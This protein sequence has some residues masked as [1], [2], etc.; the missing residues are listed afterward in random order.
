MNFIINRDNFFKSKIITKEN[1]YGYIFLLPSFIGTS[2]FC[3]FPFADVFI[4]SFKEAMTGKFVGLDNYKTV[5]N[6]KAFSLAV[7][8]TLK[9]TIIC[10]PMLIILSIFIASVLLVLV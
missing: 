10:I 3:I 6:H 2:V 7:N 1:M 4:R 8:N 5:I 9:F